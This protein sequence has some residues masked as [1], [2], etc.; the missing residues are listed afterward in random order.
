MKVL[1]L[2]PARYA[3]TRFPGK[4]LAMIAGKPMIQ[5]VY[6]RASDVFEYA[7]VA[8]DDVRIADAVKE[9]GGKVVM[10]SPSHQSGTDRCAEAL[11]RVQELTS[12]KFDVVVNI[13]GDEPFIQT[14]QLQK[15]AGCFADVAVQIATLVKAFGS[16]EDIFNPNSPKVILNVKSEAIY[17]SRSVIP[18]IRGKEKEDWKYN[19]KYFKH[20]GL[21]AYRADVLR[22]IT[23]LPQS[24]LEL[25][26]SLEQLR[27]IENGY[28]IK[29]VETDLETLAVDTPDDLE[30][31]KEYANSVLSDHEKD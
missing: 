7:Y 1:G 20:I 22:E 31:V 21:Y 30:R 6:Q 3:S 2:I 26:E 29:V 28:K 25:S 5:W 15:V 9:F 11:E 19:R 24:S 27:W 4:P 23:K 16:N 14:L 18:F 10:T 17:F 13:Q 12:V 8:T